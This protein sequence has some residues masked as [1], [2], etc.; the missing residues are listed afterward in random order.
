M[1]KGEYGRDIF[2]HLFKLD[3]GRY[4][5]EKTNLK[6]LLCVVKTSALHPFSLSTR[7]YSGCRF[8]PLV[9]GCWFFFD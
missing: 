7:K 6:R 1:K 3:E 8:G 2:D 9:S 5:N 4:C